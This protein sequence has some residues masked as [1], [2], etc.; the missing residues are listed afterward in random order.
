MNVHRI[1]TA[2]AG[3]VAMALIG[4]G[5]LAAPMAMPLAKQRTEAG[6]VAIAIKPLKVDAGA[7]RWSF[8]V[9]LAAVGGQPREDLLRAAV[10]LN[11]A[12]GTQEAPLAWKPDARSDGRSGTLSFNPIRPQPAAIELRIQRSGEKAPRVFRWDLDCPCNNHAK[13]ALPAKS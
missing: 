13:H 11:R 9:S 3:A 4:G 1:L 7:K 2:L 10:L 8:R 5:A 6:G 12:A